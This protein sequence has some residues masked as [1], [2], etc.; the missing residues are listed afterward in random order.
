[1]RQKKLLDQNGSP[2]N[3]A[4]ISYEGAKS[5]GRVMDMS[6]FRQAMGLSQGGFNAAY[7]QPPLQEIA[8]KFTALDSAGSI[9][10]L[11]ELEY[12]KKE[13]FEVQYE[14]LPARSLFPVTNEAGPGRKYVTYR[15]F[16]KVGQAVL[17]GNFA[18]DL[19]RADV[20]AREEVIPVRWIGSSYGYNLGEIQASR[21]VGGEPIDAKRAEAANRAIEEAVNEFAF[22]GSNDAA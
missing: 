19:P 4:V 6:S 3:K 12:I 20:F 13:V 5:N 17:V 21:Q 18:D 8:K 7:R 9:F 11:R 22:F 1:M 10:F 16:D 14:D 2:I 15:I